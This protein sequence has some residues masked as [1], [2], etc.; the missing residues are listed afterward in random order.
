MTI[1]RRKL[2]LLLLLLILATACVVVALL[3]RPAKE[4]A[5]AAVEETPLPVQ[6]EPM[7]EETD[8][9]AREKVYSAEIKD[10]FKHCTD[11]KETTSGWYPVRFSDARLKDYRNYPHIPYAG[12]TAGITMEFTTAAPTVSF[13][14]EIA[15]NLW[16]S[17]FE[18]LENGMYSE[19]FETGSRKWGHVEYTRKVTD[20][21]SDIIIC[22]PVASET[23]IV[24]PQLGDFQTDVTD[25]KPKLLV[26]GDS[27]SQGLFGATPSRNWPFLLAQA[28]GLDYLNLSV[29]GETFRKAALDKS[30]G[31]DPDHI[32]VALGTNDLF[33]TRYINVIEADIQAYLE[34]LTE[35][36]AGT[37]VTVITP[38]AQYGMNAESNM[39]NSVLFEEV[40][41]AIES[42]AAQYGCE[43][44]DGRDLFPGTVEYYAPNDGV[45]PGSLGFEIIAKRLNERMQ[46]SQK[47][48]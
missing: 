9:K 16:G 15:A 22:L 4:A 41:K 47:A 6:E 10:V 48:K 12:C 7:T 28:Q 11:V 13:G 17:G 24:D 46:V 27:I 44:I 29:G 30:I 8:D 37:P 25:D 21:P 26:L 18:V 34:K 38:I 43:M 32:I 42:A 3:M 14:Y 20:G 5:A 36:Y 23:T 40:R 35:I 39:F 33:N 1:D 19:Y 2:G 45:H 31:F